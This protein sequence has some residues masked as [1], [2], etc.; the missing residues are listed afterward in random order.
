MPS[1]GRENVAPQ[2][3]GVIDGIGTGLLLCSLGQGN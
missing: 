1:L 3:Q 2:A